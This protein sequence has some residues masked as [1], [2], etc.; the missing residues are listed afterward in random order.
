[1]FTP[2]SNFF[3]LGSRIQGKNDSRIQ[4]KK[5]SRIQGKKRF[6]DPGSASAPKHL[7]IVTQK[8]FLSS[9]NNDPGCSSRIRILIFY[10]SRIQGQI[11]R[12]RI[13]TISWLGAKLWY[14]WLDHLENTLQD[15][16]LVDHTGLQLTP[17]VVRIVPCRNN[18]KIRGP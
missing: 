3:H 10:P 1:M 5:D 2:D 8:L 4:G 13:I 14:S 18:I 11:L 12:H 6:P 9:R 15:E 7:S 16:P 17:W